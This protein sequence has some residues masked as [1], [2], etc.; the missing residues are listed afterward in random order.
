MKRRAVIIALVLCAAG[1][2]ALPTNE[3]KLAG[4]LLAG[5]VL[6]FAACLFVR[7]GEPLART[8]LDV[9]LVAFLAL[10]VL[11][12]ILA[13]DPRVSFAPSVSRREGLIDYFVYLPMALAAARLSRLEVREILEVVLA[14]AALIG[15]IAIGQYYGADAAAWVGGRGFD[16]GFR[17]WGTLGNPDFLGGYVALV[18]PIGVAMAAH[19][20]ERRRW[21][22]YAAAT[23]LL[24]GALLG[25][26]TR[27][28]WAASGLAAIA[29]LWRLPRSAE[30]AR[31]LALLG[32]TCIAVTAVMI[33][34]QPAVSLR[35]RAQSAAAGPA[36]SSM[37]GKLWI[38]QHVLPMIRERPVFGW[39]FSAVAGH[40]PGI[41]TPDYYRIFGR[42][43]VL[44][45]VA[46]NDVL[47]VSVNMGLAGL[48]AYLWIWAVALQAAHDAGRPPTSPVAAEAAGIF[49]GLIAYF[50][51]LQFLWSHIG[52]AN[53]FW[54]LAGV[55][56]ALRRADES[57]SPESESR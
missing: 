17:S 16:Y 34:T 21:W 45:D 12:T 2:P 57:G 7:S 9:P 11:S 31:R 18:L 53:V 30:V 50:V 1:V 24:Y 33:A 54:V 52:V 41:G 20:T 43:T 39:G 23:I 14:A 38:W 37:Q 10:A 48:A 42:G 4:T 29:L 27:S 47:Q 3:M 32:L 55:A 6:L 15:G 28:A 26:Q 56:T 25:S 8:P 40:L 13:P 36:D 51:W 44:I 19:A 35:A 49:G 5:C 22:G 46:H